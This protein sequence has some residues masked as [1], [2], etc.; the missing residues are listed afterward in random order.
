MVSQLKLKVPIADV[1]ATVSEGA[2][3]RPL[4][5]G[6]SET[7]LTVVGLGGISS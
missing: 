3:L 2:T 1:V 5:G 6:P 4:T 7:E